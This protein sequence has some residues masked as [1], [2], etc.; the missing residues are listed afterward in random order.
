ML[1]FGWRAPRK[2][3]DDQMTHQTAII[4]SYPFVVPNVQPTYSLHALHSFLSAMACHLVFI[5]LSEAS[6]MGKLSRIRRI[7]KLSSRFFDRMFFFDNKA[8]F[9]S[10]PVSILNRVQAG[11]HLS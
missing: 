1:G 8:D 11:G 6:L 9:P 3:A 10:V 4:L 5:S 7:I 2:A